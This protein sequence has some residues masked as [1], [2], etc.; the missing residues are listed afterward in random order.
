MTIETQQIRSSLATVITQYSNNTQFVRGRDTVAELDCSFH[1][2]LGAVEFATRINAITFNESMECKATVRDIHD[3]QE[4][5]RKCY[6]LPVD[7]HDALTERNRHLKHLL[8]HSVAATAAR[9]ATLRSN[10]S[11]SSHIRSA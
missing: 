6:R 1:K 8:S 3:A 5:L 9:V 2:T 11:Y 4:S 10:L 7:S